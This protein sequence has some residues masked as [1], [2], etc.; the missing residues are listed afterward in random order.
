LFGRR[1]GEDRAGARQ[2]SG[3]TGR[4]VRSTLTDGGFAAG[5]ISVEI[6]RRTKKA[7]WRRQSRRR[8][9]DR[10]VPVRRPCRALH[11]FAR[12]GG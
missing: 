4:Q 2:R 1:R 12:T 7:G 5:S 8:R 11:A 3:Q 10:A 6:S 9:P